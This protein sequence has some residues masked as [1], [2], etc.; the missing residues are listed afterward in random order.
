MDGLVCAGAGT[1]KTTVLA[2]RFLN[3]TWELD[4]PNIRNSVSKIAAITFTEKAA[5]EMRE[6]IFELAFNNFI[7]NNDSRWFT[8]YRTVE[9]ASICTIHSFCRSLLAQNPLK[10]GINPSFNVE[11]Q[12]IPAQE[13]TE[14]FLSFLVEGQLDKKDTVLWMIEKLSRKN[15]KSCLSE[16]FRKRQYLGKAIHKLAGANPERLAKQY[17]EF[18]IDYINKK[19]ENYLSELEDI[20]Q[21]DPLFPEISGNVIDTLNAF[22]S[23]E[24]KQYSCG[25][26][27]LNRLNDILRG[28]RLK[29]RI[30]QLRESLKDEKKISTAEWKNLDELA[31]LAVEIA[32]LYVEFEKYLW[33]GYEYDSTVDFNELLIRTLALFDK[34]DEKQKQNIYPAN[35]LVDEFQDTSP[36]QWDIINEL[37]KYS[38]NVLLVGDEKQS[39]YRFRGA[40]VSVIRKAEQFIIDRKGDKLPQNPYPL[41]I[42]YRSSRRLLR[43]FNRIFRHHFQ[44]YWRQKL[45]LHLHEP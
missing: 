28:K 44:D 24:V 37:A 40:D 1:G 31:T 42:N 39:I 13:Y 32:K 26:D 45:Q 17:K 6:R 10:A 12:D 23:Q 15:I 41:D 7:E 22:L 2:T 19:A 5:N 30:S 29:G 21:N 3:Y 8:I 16:I 27:I 9:M 36:I 34:L 35:I 25:E 4:L 33:A 14:E 18:V 20:M 11:P 38:K 43:L